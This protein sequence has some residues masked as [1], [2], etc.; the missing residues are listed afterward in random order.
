MAMW[1]P[2]SE[3]S[4]GACV[5]RGGEEQ[6]DGTDS[7]KSNEDGTAKQSKEDARVPTDL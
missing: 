4:L 7:A 2:C 1:L 6:A 3:P 5:G